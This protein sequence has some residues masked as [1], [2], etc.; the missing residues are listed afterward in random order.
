MSTGARRTR[1]LAGV[2]G[3]AALSLVAAGCS[4]G[5][6]ADGDVT[7]QFAQWWEPELPDGAFAEI[8]A[9][10]EE[11]NPGVTVELVSAPYASTQEQLF[12]GS[13]S[14]TMPDVMGLDA[15]WVNDFA[16]QGAIADLSAMMGEYGYDDSQLASQVQVDGST[17]M[18]P[19][20]NFIYPL[21]TNDDLL[22]EAGVDAPPTTRQE[23]LDTAVAISEL[24]GDTT[25]WA[26]PLS[27]EQPNGVLNDVMPW[28]WSS[29]GSMLAD[30][31]PDLTNPEMTSAV[32][33]VQELWDAGAVAPGSF[34]MKEQDKVE[35]FTNG[36]VGMMIS[37]LAHINLLQETNPDLSFSVSAIPTEEGYDGESG[38]T[39][40]SWGIGVSESTE[41]PE[42][43]W[44]LIEYLMET[45]TNG[46]LSTIANGFPGNT[47]AVPGFVEDD[48][49]MADAFEIYQNTTPVNEF[50]GLPAAEQLMRSF[51]EQLQAALNGDQSV[52]Q[53]L[54]QTQTAWSDEF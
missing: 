52:D 39:Y 20:V 54:E 49:L 33:Y 42:E 53:M 50:S 44:A 27:L 1:R 6:D 18:I 22:A 36:R 17:Y 38:L 35:E 37:S 51:A 31:Q 24:G 43:A 5:G 25:G 29:G 30:G 10:F 41:H 13:A 11:A 45:E 19:V 7:I 48:P 34:T 16:N 2:A 26:L 12:A 3:L 15:V 4:G 8:I 14:G 21:F 28:A 9:G 46:E 23:F 32:E 40:A 47:E